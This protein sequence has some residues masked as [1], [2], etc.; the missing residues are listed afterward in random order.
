M[1]FISSGKQT[2]DRAG[3][4]KV[5]MVIQPVEFGE[6]LPQ[7]HALVNEFVLL[8]FTCRC[9]VSADG[10]NLDMGAYAAAIGKGLANHYGERGRI[11]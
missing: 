9:G 11:I 2:Y 8:K 3:D 1:Y 10:H 5:A 6:R 4:V 7:P